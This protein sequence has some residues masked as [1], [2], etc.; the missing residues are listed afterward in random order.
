V[1]SSVMSEVFLILSLI[2]FILMT[3]NVTYGKAWTCKHF[4]DTFPVKN[5]LREGG[6]LL[7]LLFRFVLEYAITKAQANQE[8]LKLNG[9]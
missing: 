7:L 2:R 4:C 9:I 5:G 1:C 8:G 6:A 3:L